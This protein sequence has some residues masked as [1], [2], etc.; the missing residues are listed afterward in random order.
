MTAD[1]IFE[2]A[3]R[4][5]LSAKKEQDSSQVILL[6][7]DDNVCLFVEKEI[8][9]R[10][11]EGKIDTAKTV[12]EANE[13]LTQHA[14]DLVVADLCLSD[15]SALDIIAAA[16]TQA[17]SKNKKT[18]FVA[19]TAY[20]A[21]NK[22][23]E[24]LQA[25][26]TTVVTKPLTEEEARNFMLHPMKHPSYEYTDLSRPV[27]DL[28]LGMDRLCEGNKEKAIQ[29]LELLIVSLTEDLE[30]LKSAQSEHDQSSMNDILH[31]IRG[32][33]QYSATP[34]FEKAVQDLQA[35][36]REKQTQAIA[37]GIQNLDEQMK[38]LKEAYYDLL[39]YE[40]Y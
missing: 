14:Y 2:S 33:L 23:Q 8:L 39:N 38:W 20:R 28:K 22:H 13:K 7:E 5:V 21:Q 3:P 4:A 34:A 10:L 9:T 16:R 35:A 18:P 26:F 25:G 27:I 19:L 30:A 24:A 36:F 32:A 37:R 15:G 40:W 12:F 11:T 1:S 17:E 31:K 29:A 6:I